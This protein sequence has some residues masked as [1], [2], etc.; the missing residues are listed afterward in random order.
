MKCRTHQ[1]PSI[2]IRINQIR[3]K[4]TDLIQF[5]T[6]SVQSD[7]LISPKNGHRWFTRTLVVDWQK[8]PCFTSFG[9]SDT[10]VTHVGGPRT[11]RPP[12]LLTSIRVSSVCSSFHSFPFHLFFVFNRIQTNS[13]D[14]SRFLGNFCK[15][16]ILHLATRKWTIRPQK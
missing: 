1:A 11:R 15:W 8:I 4:I 12:L 9:V 13:A 10:E 14:C 5:E 6:N 16:K 2:D 7:W 3:P